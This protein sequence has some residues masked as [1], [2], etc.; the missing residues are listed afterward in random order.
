MGSV[1]DQEGFQLARLKVDRYGEGGMTALGK[2]NSVQRFP[3]ILL[4]DIS[5]TSILKVL[6]VLH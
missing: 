5:T 3:I 1:F 4:S 2:R 6:D